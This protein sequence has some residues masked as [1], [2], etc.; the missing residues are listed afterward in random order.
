MQRIEELSGMR[1]MRARTIGKTDFPNVAP[2]KVVEQLMR[3]CS[4]TVILEFPQTVIQ[5][6][7]SKPRT[8]NEKLIKNTSYYLL[9]GIILRCLWHLC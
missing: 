1:G 4:G 7:I 6:G 9:L 8:S 2:M 5:K 3:Q